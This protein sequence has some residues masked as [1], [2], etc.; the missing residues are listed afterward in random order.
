MEKQEELLIQ[1]SLFTFATDVYTEAVKRQT[2][3]FLENMFISPLSIWIAMSM[4]EAGSRGDTKKEMM[5]ALRLPSKMSD[6]KIHE[7]V[8]STLMKCFES[9]PGVDVALANRLF[10]L[11]PATIQK[12]FVNLLQKYYKS[13]ADEVSKR[14]CVCVNILARFTWFKRSKTNAHKQMGLW[15][16][17]FKEENTADAPFHRLDGSVQTVKMMHN[18]FGFPYINLPEIDA[19]ALKIPFEHED[20]CLL[21]VLPDEDSGLPQLLSHLRKPG[22]ISVILE[23][24]FV[25]EKVSLYLPRFKLGEKSAMDVSEILHS[26]G[27]NLVFEQGKA[28]LSG[29]CEDHPIFVSKILHKAI[30]EVDEQGATAA[31]ATATIM[32][33]CALGT[34][35]PI[36]F[37]VDHPFFVA[38]VHNDIT[39]VFMGNVCQPQTL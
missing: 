10:V 37:L 15:R 34:T 4:T 31:A 24:E 23:K 35:E 12:T 13:Y 5:K 32:K 6:E 38:I 19:Q 11:K 25:Y 8:G 36:K 18:E 7:T 3:S 9:V 2:A 28:D 16:R 17:V 21:I 29:I 1:S 39:P 30:L 27:M 14:V 33:G 22:A 20:W 26:L